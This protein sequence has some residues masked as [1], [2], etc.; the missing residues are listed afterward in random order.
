MLV[1]SAFKIHANFLIMKKSLL[2]EEEML[3]TIK[4]FNDARKLHESENA[5]V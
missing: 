2:T 1:F 3:V 4:T 5:F